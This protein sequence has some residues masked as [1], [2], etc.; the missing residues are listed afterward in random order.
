MHLPARASRRG[1][2]RRGDRRAAER[3]LGRGRKPAARAEGAA[4][5]SRVRRASTRRR[6]AMIDHTG[7][8]VSDV[9]EAQGVLSRGARAARLRS[10]D[11]VGRLRGLRRRAEAGLL[12]RPGQ[13]RTVPPIHVAFRARHARAGRCLLPG[14]DRRGR[15]RQ[16]PAGPA[17]ALSPELLRR[18]RPR[19]RTATTSRPVL[20]TSGLSIGPRAC[21]AFAV[22]S[23]ALA[24]LRVASSTAA[25]AGLAR[26]SRCA[27][28]VA[29]PAGS[30]IDALARVDRRPAEG[31]RSA[32]RSSSK[33]NRRR[34]APSR[35]PKWQGGAGR[36]HDAARVQRTARVRPAARRSFLR[37]RRRT[38]RR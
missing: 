24:A 37:R 26:P 10:A 27:F 13:R 12:D 22:S 32:S 15:S 7:V 31:S 30:S 14:R 28:V 4:R 29:A 8:N 11:G 3:R 20:P 19:S 34:A 25:R 9:S 1:G 17:S 35:P 18:V 2:R 5:V 16:R 38:W 21:S 36:L 33:T 6:S 23:A